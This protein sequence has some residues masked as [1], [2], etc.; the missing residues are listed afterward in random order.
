MPI[1]AYTFALCAITISHPLERTVSKVSTPTTLR[2][3][4]RSSEAAKLIPI[5]RAWL[6]AKAARGEIPGAHRTS[7]TSGH[8]RFDPD[9]FDAYVRALREGKLKP[10][11]AL[12]P[13]KR[14]QHV[15]RE[16]AMQRWLEEFRKKP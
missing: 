3:A 4:Y 5:C 7:I 16:V 14:G 2:P 8:W 13:P 6:V 9:R 1:G 10:P 12:G 11:L 15:P